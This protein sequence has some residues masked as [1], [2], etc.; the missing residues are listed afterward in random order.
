MSATSDESSQLNYTLYGYC[1]DH[2]QELWGSHKLLF[3]YD[4]Q[5]EEKESSEL[6]VLL[7]LKCDFVVC[8][9]TKSQQL[10]PPEILRLRN[11]TEEL[12]ARN[13]DLEEHARK[14]HVEILARDNWLR[15]FDQSYKTEIPNSENVFK[16]RMC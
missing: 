11:M 16:Y 1:S 10:L 8:M 14:N 13:V 5:V 7:C 12:Q 2:W 15:E 6:S 4:G 9:M 3:H